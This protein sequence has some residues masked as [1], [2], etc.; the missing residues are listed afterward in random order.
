[1]GREVGLL[2]YPCWD[3]APARFIAKR[4]VNGVTQS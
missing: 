1:M 4:K 2:L 3:L